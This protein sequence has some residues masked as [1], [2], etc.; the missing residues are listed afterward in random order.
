M[1]KTGQDRVEKKLRVEEGKSR[2]TYIIET[3]NCKKKKRVSKRTVQEEGIIGVK[4]AT[5]SK[6]N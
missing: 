4:T 3:E 6:G 2:L 5:L 1:E